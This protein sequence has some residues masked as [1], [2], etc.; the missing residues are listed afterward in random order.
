[1][2]VKKIIK[3]VVENDLG[4]K[5][6]IYLVYNS[7][8]LPSLLKQTLIEIEKLENVMKENNII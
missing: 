8:A 3:H 1:M 4:C 6:V 7:M 5:V 2:R